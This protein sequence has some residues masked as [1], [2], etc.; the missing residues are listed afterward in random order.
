[1]K[2]FKQK[3]TI[4][5]PIEIMLDVC[6]M[7]HTGDLSNRILGSNE[8]L[9]EAIIEISYLTN[10]EIQKAAIENIIDSVNEWNEC[11]YGEEDAEQIALN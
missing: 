6:R 10:N 4:R 7:I 9:G 8:V 2:P 5:I 11:R 3:Q 1:M